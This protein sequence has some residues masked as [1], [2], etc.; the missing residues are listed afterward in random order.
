ME[1]V[2]RNSYQEDVYIRPLAY[3]SEEKIGL[4][5]SGIPDDLTI[6]TTPFGEYLDLSKGIK[7]CTSTWRTI[8]PRGKITVLEMTG[9]KEGYC[10]L[11]GLGTGELLC[12]LISQ[13][14]LYIIALDPD[15]K[16]P[17]VSQGYLAMSASGELTAP[18]VY[19][20][21][22]NAWPLGFLALIHGWWR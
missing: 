18:L 20:R 10:L 12:E 14:N 6:Y 22:G 8:P 13:S 11:L 16:N 15:T 21:G 4:G 5:L 9:Q 17:R 3:K 7:V 2:E 19:A 1:L